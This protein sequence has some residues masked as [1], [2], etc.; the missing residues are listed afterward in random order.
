MSIKQGTFISPN[1]R[2]LFFRYWKSAAGFWW[3]QTAL[4]AW[5]LFGLL[6]ILILLQLFIQYLINFWNRDFF[7]ALDKR[8]V[9]LLWREAKL[10]LPLAISSICIAIFSVWG[11][12]TLQ[13]KWRKW[14]SQHLINYWLKDNHYRRM[15]LMQNIQLNA[16]YRISEDARVAT[17]LPI[18]L[19]LGFLTSVLTAFTFITV[20]WRIGGTYNL[21]IFGLTFFIPGYL[22]IAAIGYSLLL[23]TVMI[24]IGRYLKGA[25]EEKNH[26]EAALRA[27]SSK[28]REHGE[29]IL[30]LDDEK[31]E[32]HA[33]RTMLEN[34]IESWKIICWQLMRTTLVI[35]GNGLIAPVI[36]LLLCTP[37]YLTGGI[38]LGQVVQAA[39]AFVT[40]QS[41]FN[42][43]MDNYPRI[44]DWLSSANRVAF[45]LLAL[46]EL[47]EEKSNEQTFWD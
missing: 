19:M 3:G 17:D 5:S 30:H 4:K 27:A 10:F 28:L 40:V 24:L 35:H 29:G 31:E 42:W 11:K 22:V 21:N 26:C 44:A 32:K 14:L 46:D 43:L 8:D 39:A 7:N 45:L 37:K 18:D 25:V 36:G 2:R 6:I 20:L 13:R 41:C 33:V 38:T 12:M 1:A 15:K 16:E 34:V 9:S 47:E 23:T